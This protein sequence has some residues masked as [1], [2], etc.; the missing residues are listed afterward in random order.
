MRNWALEM[1]RRG[2][3]SGLTFESMLLR[4]YTVHL[5]SILDYI[6]INTSDCLQH[7]I[8]YIHYTTHSAEQTCMYLLPKDRLVCHCPFRTSV[9]ELLITG[10][11]SGQSIRCNC[12][13]PLMGPGDDM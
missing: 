8:D 6:Q 7:L 10:A 12:P 9:A 5:I 4:Y 2:Q 13:C 11:R 1:P 3:S